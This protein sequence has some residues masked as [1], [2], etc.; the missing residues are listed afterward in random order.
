M[1]M[2]KRMLIEQQED[3]LEARYGKHSVYI[4]EDEEHVLDD[5]E[6]DEWLAVLEQKAAAERLAQSWPDNEDGWRASMEEAA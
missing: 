3:A 6:Y 4:T 5:D 1:G 2:Y